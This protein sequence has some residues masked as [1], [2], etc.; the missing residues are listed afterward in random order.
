M[1]PEE[2]SSIERVPCVDEMCTGILDADGVCGTCGRMGNTVRAIER[3][4]DEDASGPDAAAAEE[5]AAVQTDAEI[6]SSSVDPDER[7]PCIDEMCIGIVGAD[8]RCG[9]CGKQALEASSSD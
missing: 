9:T 3:A 8:G 7:V 4:A 1:D 2:V 6:T 5:L